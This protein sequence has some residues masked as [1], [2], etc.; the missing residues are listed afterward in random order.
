MWTD[1][2]HTTR[3][4]AGALACSFVHSIVRSFVRLFVQSRAHTYI[5]NEPSQWN[6]TAKYE[7]T[8][9][10]KLNAN[11]FPGPNRTAPLRYKVIEI[12]ILAGWCIRYIEIELKIHARFGYSM[13]IKWEYNEN[14]IDL[15]VDFC[16]LFQCDRNS[17]WFY[18]WDTGHNYLCAFRRFNQESIHKATNKKKSVSFNRTEVW[19]LFSRLVALN[20]F[21]SM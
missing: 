12:N 7:P 10:H 8:D 3:Q 19:S 1:R 2:S 14:G 11:K 18:V 6:Q 20:I 17:F 16:C 9:E 5:P 4:S 15:D 21:Q 13:E